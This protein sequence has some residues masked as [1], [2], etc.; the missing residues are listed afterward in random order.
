MKSRHRSQA[1]RLRR[2]AA[3]STVTV[4]VLLGTP[5]ASAAPSTVPSPVHTWTGDQPGEGYGWAVSELRDVDGD[6]ATDAIIGAPFHATAA[7]SNAG[8]VDLRS[9][10]S[11]AVLHSY[12][13]LPGELLGY[14]IADAGDVD[15]DGVHDVVI[16]A[17]QGGLFCTG[18]EAG[19]GHAYVRSGATGAL[20]LTLG[21]A[22]SRAHLGAAVGSAGDINR[23]GHAD[24]LVGAPCAGPTGAESGAAYVY[25]GTSGTVLRRFAGD[26]AGDHFGIGTAPVGDIDHDRITDQAVAATDAGVGRRGVV[27][28]FSG[29]TGKRRLQLSGGPTT[30]DLGWFFV[31]GVGDVNRDGTPDIYAGDFDAGPNGNLRGGAFVFSGATGKTLHVFPGAAPNAG[32]GPGR[33]AGDVNR[34]A[35]PD[36][37]VGSYTSSDGAPLA[38]R[39]DV[40][41]GRTGR[42]IRTYVSS[43][44]G[45]N[46]GFDAVGI[47]DVTGDGRPELLVSAASGDTV[48]V[49]PTG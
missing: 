18:T 35:V 42:P 7:G 45:E 37:V 11:G 8:H 16:G 31:A 26:A 30:V 20:L 33:G 47:G 27:S 43:I 4:L 6:G 5:P 14:A 12:V 29:R 28:V 49:L 48:Y 46:L 34:D 19:P 22:P 13:G 9:G 39:V 40:Y 23:D 38:G 36:I 21:G 15:G 32:A 24:V 41:S 17:P 10:R 3:C 44:A 25:S 1:R 2:V